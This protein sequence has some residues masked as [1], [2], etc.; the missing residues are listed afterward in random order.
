[1]LRVEALG[2]CG[3]PA[4]DPSGDGVR[5]W[6]EPVAVAALCPL[7]RAPRL[8]RGEQPAATQVQRFGFGAVSFVVLPRCLYLTDD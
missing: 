1:M 2:C 5:P 6:K 8:R 7:V 4:A 3:P